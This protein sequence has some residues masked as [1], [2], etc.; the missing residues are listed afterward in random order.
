MAEYK[1]TNKA[2]VDLNEIWNYTVESWS[3]NQADTYYEV[4]LGFCQDIADNPEIGRNYKD[5]APDLFGLKVKRHEI[6]I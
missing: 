6:P 3:E 4:L 2:V 5:F 1:L